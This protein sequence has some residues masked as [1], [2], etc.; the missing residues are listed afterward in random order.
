MFLAFLGGYR[1]LSFYRRKIRVREGE[2]VYRKRGRVSLTASFGALDGDT[3]PEGGAGAS[4]LGFFKL[5]LGPEKP[6]SAS[7][8]TQN[9]H[10]R[11]YSFLFL[12]VDIIKLIFHFLIF[13]R[14]QAIFPS[15]KAITTQHKIKLKKLNKKKDKKGK[16]LVFFII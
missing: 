14:F 11:F 4:R 13:P 16:R 5:V 3:G 1:N 6:Y 7:S 12:Y 15:D 8:L 2:K 10:S 9:G